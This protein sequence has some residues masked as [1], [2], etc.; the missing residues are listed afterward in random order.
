MSESARPRFISALATVLF[1]VTIG[2]IVLTILFTMVFEVGVPRYL[3]AFVG[4]G[5]SVTA[6]ASA[7]GFRRMAPWSVRLFVLWGFFAVL[8]SLLMT[9]TAGIPSF[10][11]LV[12]AL[13]GAL[14]VAGLAVYLSRRF[15]SSAAADDR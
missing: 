5:Y 10:R 3:I 15:R 9:A 2:G 4:I 14:G 13:V 12:I 8:L 7:V 11:V 1:A 6:L